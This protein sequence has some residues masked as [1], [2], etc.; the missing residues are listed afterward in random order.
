MVNVES[1]LSPSGGETRYSQNINSLTENLVT[2]GASLFVSD[3]GLFQKYLGQPAMKAFRRNTPYTREF[4][5][6]AQAT[7]NEAK[8]TAKL[9]REQF[10]TYEKI[11]PITDTKG[12]VIGASKTRQY[13]EHLEGLKEAKASYK[14]SMTE[15]REKYYQSRSTP[16]AAAERKAFSNKIRG[17][18]NI[19]RNV[20]TLMLLSIGLDLATEAMT[21]GISKVAAKKEEDYLNGSTLLDSQT[22]YTMRQRA[23][24]AIHDSMMNVRQVMGNEAQFM[25]R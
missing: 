14:Q 7:A 8:L 10:G 13:Q 2:F 22:S 9:F 25:H 18:K 5:A 3:S 11:K 12:N 20:G 24:M 1:F 4:K 16:Q 23:V 15:A 19:S 17:F 21:P 6:A